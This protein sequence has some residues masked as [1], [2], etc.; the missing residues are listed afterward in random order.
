MYYNLTAAYSKV[1]IQ[2]I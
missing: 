1:S 2:R